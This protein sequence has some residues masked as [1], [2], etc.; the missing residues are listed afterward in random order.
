[1]RG[2]EVDVG[3]V[4]WSLPGPET[5]TASV[6]IVDDHPANL[7]AVESI[8]APLN[9]RLV[10]VPS[11]EDALRQLLRDQFALILLDVQ[12]AGLD[13]L[14][15]AALIKQNETTRH[16]PIIFLTAYTPNSEQIFKGYKEGAVDYL[17]KPFDPAALRAKVS[18]FVD[19]YLQSQLIKRQ[20]AEL[21]QSARRFEACRGRSCG[22][23]SA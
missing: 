23:T 15:T 4:P 16:T 9:L 12:M 19:L 14:Q 22:N 8:L 3:H 11:G 20:A 7:L 18:V 21:V 17:L 10:M 5:P 13:G 6:L 2:L 1:M